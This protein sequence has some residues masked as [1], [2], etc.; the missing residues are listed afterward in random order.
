MPPTILVIG[1]SDA[2]G[3]FDGADTYCIPVHSKGRMLTISAIADHVTVFRYIANAS[4]D[5]RFL[6]TSVACGEGG[7][8]PGQVADLFRDMPENVYLQ[9]RLAYGLK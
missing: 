6:V 8:Q 5:A 1:S 9:A 4:P 2:A 3:G 7:Y